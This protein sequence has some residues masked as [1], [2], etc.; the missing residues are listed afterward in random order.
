MGEVLPLILYGTILRVTAEG[1]ETPV[2]EGSGHCVDRLGGLV[3]HGDRYTPRGKEPCEKCTC[4]RGRPD[5]CF[6]TSCSPPDQCQAPYL[7]GSGECCDYACNGTLPGSPDGA[8]VLSATN[9]GLRLV[10]GTVTS[11]LIL[12]LLL[13]M[14]HRLRKRRLLVMIRSQSLFS[15]L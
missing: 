7:R 5:S 9:L 1:E 3:G 4:Q 12:A 8:D 15:L 10:A 13:F 14:I 2:E 6:I 11:F